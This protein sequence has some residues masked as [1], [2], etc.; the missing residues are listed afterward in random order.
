MSHSITYSLASSWLGVKAAG[1]NAP[2]FK[3]LAFAVTSTGLIS[4]YK[5]DRTWWLQVLFLPS[6]RN[7]TYFNLGEVNAQTIPGPTGRSHAKNHANRGDITGHWSI[8]SPSRKRG[9]FDSDFNNRI[10][11]VPESQKRTRETVFFSGWES[12]DPGYI[13]TPYPAVAVS[14]PGERMWA[15]VG[16][17]PYFTRQ[18]N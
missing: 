8:K 3:S 18:G 13:E 10:D 17:F 1:C 14:G 11:Y 4:S 9:R 2:P 5:S 7:S 6:P 15:P 16:V 12:P